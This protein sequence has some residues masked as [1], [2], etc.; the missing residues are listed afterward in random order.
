MNRH[1]AILFAAAAVL[2]G[3]GR[4][5]PSLKPEVR[6]GVQASPAFIP[7]P[8]PQCPREDAAALA[9][10][11]PDPEP[12]AYEAGLQEAE[13]LAGADAASVAGALAR[14]RQSLPEDIYSAR[15][16]RL[17]AATAASGNLPRAFD[18]LAELDAG[19]D[20]NSGLNAIA[21][22]CA[23]APNVRVGFLQEVEGI[24][25][26]ELRDQAL[27]EFWR[28]WLELSPRDALSALD[29]Q[30]ANSSTG[31]LAAAVRVW[32]S[33]NPNEAQFWLESQASPDPLVSEAIQMG[34]RA[35]A[36]K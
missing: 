30:Q 29:A 5:T 26:S 10:D 32:G 11:H 2:T 35:A 14:W 1:P 24:Q 31:V 18:L 6:A 9:Q 7:P 34:I 12:E 16:A 19:P 4:P 17:L 22:S 20:F 21:A 3:C 36:G 23:E 15:A 27:V 28:R 33:Q 13:H 25:D 8:P